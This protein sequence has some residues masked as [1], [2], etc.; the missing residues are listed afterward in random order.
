MKRKVQGDTPTDVHGTGNVKAD[1]TEKQLVAFGAAA[2][3]YNVLEDQ[4]DA[5]LFVATGISDWLFAE[6][7][8]RIHGLDGKIAIIQKAI[9]H[10]DL[11]PS[12]KKK[13][14]E[15]VAAFGDFKKNRDTMIHA[16]I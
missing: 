3:A 2:L 4:I 8:S 13:L 16:R 14:T 15:A 7:S 9:E 12:D 1:L 11:M 6:V 10:S 5:L